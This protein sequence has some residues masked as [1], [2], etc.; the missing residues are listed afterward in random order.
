[1]QRLNALDGLRFL[2]ALVVALAHLAL[3]LF[4]PQRASF[5]SPLQQ[6]LILLFNG[7]AAVAVFFLISGFCIHLPYT[8]GEKLSLRAFYLRRFLRLGI[9]LLVWLPLAWVLDERKTSW[10]VLWSL[11]AELIYYLLYPLL[12]R[13]ITLWSWSVVYCLALSAAAGVLLLSES[14]QGCNDYGALAWILG[15]PIWLLGVRLADQW[16]TLS[17]TSPP[18][19]LALWGLR[20]A[21]ALAGWL[22][23]LLHWRGISDGWALNAFAVL[24]WYW[25]YQELVRAQ[26]H[27]FPGWLVAAGAW[28]YSYYLVHTGIGTTVPRLLG[29]GIPQDSL[30]ANAAGHLGALVGAY[31]FGRFVE[32]PAHRMARRLSTVK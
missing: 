18:S 22:A 13:A 8:Q 10:G 4:G 9:P 3:P 16:L 28:S 26:Q 21:L 1:V 31:L 17:A 23:S 29:L 14:K 7:G 15:L 30:A 25:L 11:W 12:R 2:A 5:P 24:A 20:L 27:P 19:A 32:K 6:Q